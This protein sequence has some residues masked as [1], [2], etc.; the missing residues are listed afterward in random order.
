VDTVKKKRT[1]AFTGFAYVILAAS[2]ILLAFFA[3]PL[4][5]KIRRMSPPPLAGGAEHDNRFIGEADLERLYPNI[6]LRQRKGSEKFVALTFDDG[7]DNTFTPAVLDVL[8]AKQVRATFFLIGNRVE[9]YPDIAKRIIDEGHVIG[10]HTYSHPNTGRPMGEQLRKEIE[11]MEATLARFNVAPSYLF[12]PPYGALSA[13][14]ALEIANF[15]YRLA[16][17]SV[18]SLD[19]RGLSKEEVVKNIMTQMGPGRVILQH[20]AGGPGEDLSGSVLALSEVIDTLKQQGYSF[21]TINEMFP[22]KCET[23]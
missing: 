11:Q 10:N 14:A 18:D 17:W 19:W 1:P 20:S 3:S 16:L 21:M 15:G 8:K 4:Y 22:Q 13:P 5:R 12:R 23:K 2:V 6:V 7:P 9:E